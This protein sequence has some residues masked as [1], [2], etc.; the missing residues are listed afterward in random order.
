M[1]IEDLKVSTETI[2]THQFQT[3]DTNIGLRLYKNERVLNHSH[4]CYHYYHL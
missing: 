3:L 4:D 2:S 1:G